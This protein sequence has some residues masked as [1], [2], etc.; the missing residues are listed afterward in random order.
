MRVRRKRSRHGALG[1]AGGLLPRT[2][3]EELAAGSSPAAAKT[4][5]V[6]DFV[7]GKEV[8]AATGTIV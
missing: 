7:R 4:D 8:E 6:V 3:A 2:G 5:A 1:V